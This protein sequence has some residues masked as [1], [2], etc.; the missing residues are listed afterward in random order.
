LHVGVIFGG[1]SPEHDVSV[2]TGLQAARELT[3]STNHTV[4][5]LY[6]SKVG[7]WCEV[8][9]TLEG[10]DFADGVPSRA[11]RLRLAV[12]PDGGFTVADRRIGR[13]RQLDLDA[14]LVCCHGGPGESGALQ[15]VLD[16][17]GVVHTGPSAVGAALG[18]DK[19]AFGSLVECA[20]LPVL[21]RMAFDE[22]TTSVPFAGPYIVKPRFG[23]SSIGIEIVEDVETARARAANSVHLAAGAVL[24]PFKPDYFDLQVA[25]R[26]W[27]DLQL[28]AIERPLRA[29]QGKSRILDYTDKYSGGEGMVSAPREVPALVSASLQT[30]L[31]EAA[32][33]VA[34][35]VGLSGVARLDFLSDGTEIVVNELNTIPGSLARYLWI[36]PPIPFTVLLN[37]LLE[38]ATRVPP[39]GYATTG[40]DGSVLRSASS[41]ASKL[42]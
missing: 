37:D 28:S 32:R 26:S 41:I 31:V 42:G 35:L 9:S 20:D 15:A 10:S 11:V 12:G 34:A 17:A 23:G 33:A 4:R 1:P 7:D 27:P 19:L 2:L 5:S 8:D 13:S 18:M 14:A 36:D 3:S 24:E 25:M 29:S 38:E 40:A 6:W 39:V 16:L 22:R 21:P 30:R